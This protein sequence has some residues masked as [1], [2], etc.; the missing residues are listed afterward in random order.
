MWVRCRG[1]PLKF[2]SNQCFDLVGSL[3]GIFIEVDEA[4]TSWEALEFARLRI[5]MSLGALTN[6]V[7]A[8][9]INDVL[10]Q[11]SFE[12]ESYAEVTMVGC[13]HGRWGGA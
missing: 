12:E 10:C 8:V 6:L 5:R 11:I 4:T 13:S 2:W 9:R 1:I 3:I 7:K